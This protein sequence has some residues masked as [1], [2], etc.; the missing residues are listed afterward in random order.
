M[1]SNRLGRVMAAL[2]TALTGACANSGGGQVAG[3]A[4]PRPGEVDAEVQIVRAAAIPIT[5][6][7][8]DYDSLIAHVGDARF[9]LLGEA[10]HGT[11]EF[12]RER[13]R[14]TRRLIEEKGFTVVAVEADW[15]DAYDANEFIHGNG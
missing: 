4:S 7:E 14:I 10:T 5:G 1:R 3:D 11:H 8:T 13:A 15:Q 9:V 12:Y 2:G 6:A